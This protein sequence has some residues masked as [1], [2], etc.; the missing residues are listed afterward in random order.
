MRDSECSTSESL[1]AP[2]TVGYKYEPTPIELPCIL[3]ADLMNKDE[4]YLLS[5]DNADDLSLIQDCFPR[6]DN[7]TV[8]L[9]SRD[10]VATEQVA[11]NGV[12][13]PEFFVSESCDFLSS[14]LPS[15]VASDPKKR[16]IL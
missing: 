9:T 11:A 12:T 4:S 7:G 6:D 13:V 15:A 10:P 14:L 3:D 8:W 1:R 2:A 5:F 16:A